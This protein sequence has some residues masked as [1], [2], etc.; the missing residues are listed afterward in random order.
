MADN[1]LDSLMSGA[2][3]LDDIRS[4]YYEKYKDRFV[5]STENLVNSETFLNLL[6]A[7]MTNQDPLE[8]TSNTEFITQMAS[9]SQLSYMRDSSTYAMANYA[10]SLV[11]KIATA[12]KADGKNQLT[13]TGLVESVTKVGN[14]YTVVIDGVSFD[15]SK[16]TKVQDAGSVSDPTLGSNALADS[17]ARASGMIGMYA[18]VK[19]D[20]GV[21]VGWIDTVKVNNGKITIV[22]GDENGNVIGEFDLDKVTEVTYATVGGYYPDGDVEGGDNVE[23]GDDADASD[24]VEGADDVD[25]GDDNVDEDDT[26]VEAPDESTDT[27]G[28]DTEADT[29]DGTETE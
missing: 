22:L 12:T 5:D 9:F 4:A 18:T 17:I 16:V 13:K 26:T 25:G 14:S 21:A 28:T 3:T 10:A 11:G 6:V 19:T 15:I 29:S 8:P 1:Y 24:K 27:D 23:D 7:E 2:S 20:D